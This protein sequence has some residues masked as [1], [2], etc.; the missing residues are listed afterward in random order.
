MAT[1]F[2]FFTTSQCCILPHPH[3]HS[4]RETERKQGGRENGKEHE[5][6]GCGE[7]ARQMNGRET[8]D[9]EHV[10]ENKGIQGKAGSI[11]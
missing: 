4:E 11:R 3:T 7:L 9:L 10:H 5:Q 2:G 8:V 1:R 6:K